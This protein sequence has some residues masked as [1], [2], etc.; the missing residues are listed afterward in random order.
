MQTTQLFAYAKLAQIINSRLWRLEIRWRLSW[1][2]RI[3]C[4]LLFFAGTLLAIIALAGSN[5]LQQ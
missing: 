1:N 4:D 3:I 5:Q 2:N